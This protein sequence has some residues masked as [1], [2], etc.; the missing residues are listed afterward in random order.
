MKSARTMT[1]M[2]LVFVMA[3]AAACQTM[4]GRSAGRLY[5]DNMITGKVKAE[6]T[7]EKVANLTRINVKTTN[8]IVNLN[9]VVAT[10]EDKARAEA[11]A[12]KVEGVAQ[13]QNDLQVRGTPAA[14]PR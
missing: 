1:I 13:V 9:G 7:K 2:A 5:D 8:G 3:L 11:I 10:F 4:T 12:Q 6:L 14:S